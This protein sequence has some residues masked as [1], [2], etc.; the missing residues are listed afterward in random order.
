MA[1]KLMIVF[2]LGAVELWAAAPAG[3]AMRLP[4]LLIFFTATA[5]TVG[6]GLIVILLGEKVSAWLKRKFNKKNESRPT[7]LI[8]RVWQHYGVIGWGLL[9]PLLT[10]SPLGAAVGLALGAPS[11]R[12][13]LWISIGGVIWGAVFTSLAV[14]GFRLFGH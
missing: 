6:A 3:L 8:V 1:L 12:L 2:G 4:P 5:G 7:G 11:R 10:G 14:L 13:L 9:A